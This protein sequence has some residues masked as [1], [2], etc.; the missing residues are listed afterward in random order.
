LFENE[1]DN[2]MEKDYRPQYFLSV[3]ASAP[4]AAADSPTPPPLILTL[5][6]PPVCV[7]NW[8]ALYTRLWRTSRSDSSPKPLIDWADSLYLGGDPAVADASLTGGD[9]LLEFKSNSVDT[10]LLIRSVV[11]HY[12]IDSNDKLKRIAPV[13][14]NP[15]DFVDEWLTHDWRETSGWTDAAREKAALAQW[16]RLLHKPDSFISGEFGGNPQRCRR[17]P[18]LWQVSFA[19]DVGGDK[20]YRLGQ[21]VYFQVR[22]MAPYRFTLTRISHRRDANCD[23]RDDMPDDL[24]TL[25]PLQDHR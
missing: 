24:G 9:L 15:N 22:W 17:D 11:R 2:Y 18:T 16:H 25:F 6:T 7:S 21:P 8:H 3:A 12:L 4:N 13:A 10:G 23:R 20:D 5:G 14:L 19:F 1:Q